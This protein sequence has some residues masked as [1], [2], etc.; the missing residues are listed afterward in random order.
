MG[1][2]FGVEESTKE[3]YTQGTLS[4]K[5]AGTG[6]PKFYNLVKFTLLVISLPAI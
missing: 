6:A 2:K 3:E 1:L 5:E 4:V